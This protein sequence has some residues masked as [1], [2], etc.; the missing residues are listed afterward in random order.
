MDH[1]VVFMGD[2]NNDDDD[3]VDRYSTEKHQVGIC[4][5]SLLLLLCI[6]RLIACIRPAYI[7]CS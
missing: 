5:G 7:F 6:S 3:D 4:S 2:D 1:I